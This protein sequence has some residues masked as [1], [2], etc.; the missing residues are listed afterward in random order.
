MARDVYRQADPDPDPLPRRI[1]DMI[2]AIRQSGR[3]ETL[4][5]FPDWNS[6]E[7]ARSAQAG[8]LVWAVETEF[9]FSWVKK[10][11]EHE[12]GLYWIDDEIAYAS[13]ENQI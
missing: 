6:F 2:F 1:P 7:S 10:G 3:H 11:K 13:P 4:V 5:E 8:T 12:T 9:A